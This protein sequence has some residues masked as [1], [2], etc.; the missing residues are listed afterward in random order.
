MAALLASAKAQAV[1]YEETS[2]DEED[3]ESM[4]DADHDTNLNPST[5]HSHPGDSSR[6][7]FD[8]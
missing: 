5:I 1:E 8:K 3:D 7:S 4:D 6:R 2:E